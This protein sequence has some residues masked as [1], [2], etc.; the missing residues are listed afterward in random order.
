[1]IQLEQDHSAYGFFMPVNPRLPLHIGSAEREYFGNLPR[2]VLMSVQVCQW[3]RLPISMPA[4][5]VSTNAS[6]ALPS[7]GS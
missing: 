7:R 1:M 4:S 5:P 3:F 6:T 2:S